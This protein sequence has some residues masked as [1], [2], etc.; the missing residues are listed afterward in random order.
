MSLIYWHETYLLTKTAFAVWSKTCLAQHDGL[1][2]RWEARCRKARAPRLLALRASSEADH[3]RQQRAP[4]LHASQGLPFSSLSQKH[5]YKMTHLSCVRYL[6][7][8]LRSCR[9]GLSRLRVSSSWSRIWVKC[10][11]LRMICLQRS[12]KTS[13]TLALLRADVS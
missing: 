4:L 9:V 10:I 2:R 12:T 6:R 13:S 1:Q 7:P 8:R 3:E 11:S 5:Y